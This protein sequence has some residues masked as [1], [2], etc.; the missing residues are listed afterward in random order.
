M[1]CTGGSVLTLDAHD[2]WASQATV[3]PFITCP[4]GQEQQQR[5]ALT[6]VLQQLQQGTLQPSNLPAIRVVQHE[7]RFYTLDNRRLWLFHQ[8]PHPCY[9]AATVVDKTKEFFQKFTNTT[10]RRSPQLRSSFAAVAEAA[11]DAATVPDASTALSKYM[12]QGSLEQLVLKWSEVNITN[13]NYFNADQVW[14]ATLFLSSLSSCRNMHTY[15]VPTYATAQQ[16][17]AAGSKDM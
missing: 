4:A 15:I 11:A 12:Y 8:L 10:G 3:E 6:D 7:G 17:R 14:A 16:Q 9:V 1:E 2:I 13:R 5:A